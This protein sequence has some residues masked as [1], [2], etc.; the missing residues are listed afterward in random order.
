MDLLMSD[1][2]H[3]LR[4]L[5]PDDPRLLETLVQEH[6]A[7]VY[8]L[9]L[10]ILGDADEADDAAQETFIQAGQHLDRYQP[11]TQIKSW[12]AAIT[13]NTCRGLLRKRRARQ[14]LEEVL[15]AVRLISAR[16]RSPEDL[17]VDVE[18]DEGLRR[19]VQG[20]D[21]KHRLPVILRYVHGLPVREVAAILNQPEGTIHSRLHYAHEKLRA[22]MMRAGAAGEALPADRKASQKPG[23]KEK[24]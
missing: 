13:V 6:Y 10:S 12:L 4:R 15:R 20:L 21:E 8:R 14:R 7:S 22:E 2:D 19:A 11:G 23:Q 9:A 5:P 3:L 1:F 18:G 17:A 24:L 16:P